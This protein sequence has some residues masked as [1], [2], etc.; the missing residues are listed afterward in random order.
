MKDF[1]EFID[2]LK[3]MN[4]N[5]KMVIKEDEH[6]SEY[7]VYSDLS[8]DNLVLPSGYVVG[9]DGKVLDV[10]INFDEV[11]KAKYLNIT[12]LP[13]S[14]LKDDA[15]DNS[16]DFSDS[17]YDDVYEISKPEDFI[18]YIEGTKFLYDDYLMSEG[19]TDEERTVIKTRKDE[20]LVALKNSFREFLSIYFENHLK[21]INSTN[22]SE[23]S[24]DDSIREIQNIINIVRDYLDDKEYAEYLE[25]RLDSSI[26]N[27][28]LND[29]LKPS[30]DDIQSE[31]SSLGEYDLE[32]EK[33]DIKITDNDDY[34]QLSNDELFTILND[35]IDDIKLAVKE[36]SD[37]LNE[38]IMEGNKLQAE[39]DDRITTYN[40]NQETDLKIEADG[41]RNARHFA[42]GV[43]DQLIFDLYEDGDTHKPCHMR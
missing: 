43:S 41:I 15:D 29:D 27:G 9:P 25:G 8:L 26:N 36:N 20:I 39:L 7:F 2:C 16:F 17:E 6:N 10:N 33:S 28:K 22:S 13:L 42:P 11:S 23:F 37:N 24:R 32:D 21:V 5:I 1:N 3:K 18:E 12:I 30:F 19:L 14:N 38:L 31:D 4:P 40:K 35:L 34:S